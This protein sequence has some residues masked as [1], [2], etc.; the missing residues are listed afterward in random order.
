MYNF[1]ADSSLFFSFPEVMWE[2]IVV[3]Q[4]IKLVLYIL[5]WITHTTGAMMRNNI[6]SILIVLLL[7]LGGTNI[8]LD[9]G[10]RESSVNVSQVTYQMSPWYEEHI[11]TDV[12][13]DG[14]IY[15]RAELQ[16][17]IL[18]FGAYD[19]NTFVDDNLLSIFEWG[20]I[21]TGPS[22]SPDDRNLNI[23][24]NFATNDA[25]QAETLA[26]GMVNAFGSYAN[27]YDVVFTGSFPEDSY[28]G[29]VQHY[30][31]RVTFNGHVDWISFQDIIDISVPRDIGGIAATVDVYQANSLNFNFWSEGDDLAATIGL[32]FNS[33]VNSLQG[34]HSFSL[35]DLVHVS[36]FEPS[37]Y[38][39]LRLDH[40]F[41]DVSNLQYS[42][43]NTSNSNVWIQKNT[44][45]ESHNKDYIW[46]IRTE[47]TGGSYSDITFSFDYIFVP[48]N[49][50]NREE[51]WHSIDPRGYGRADLVVYGTERASP[52][53]TLLPNATVFDDILGLNL[54]V[55]QSVHVIP[56]HDGIWMD[57]F[58]PSGYNQTMANS[59]TEQIANELS[60]I[61]LNFNH[62]NINPNDMWWDESTQESQ[63]VLSVSFDGFIN[64]TE[65]IDMVSST[66]VYSR[67]AAMQ[68]VTLNQMDTFYWNLNRDIYGPYMRAGI[69]AFSLGR[70]EINPT[71][72][73]SQDVQMRAT[74]SLFNLPLMSFGGSIPWNEYSSILSIH[75]ETYFD[76]NWDGLSFQPDRNNGFDWWTNRWSWED[77]GRSFFSYE[78]QVFSS[79]P[80]LQDDNGVPYAPLGSVDVS[81]D[82]KYLPG[83]AD[84]ESPWGNLYYDNGAATGDFGTDHS[85]LGGQVLSGSENIGTW[86]SDQTGPDYWNGTQF[87]QRFPS[88]GIASVMG[89]MYRVDAPVDLPI[90]NIQIPM[91]QDPTYT[92]YWSANLPTT[93]Y[94]DGEWTM[95]SDVFDN[96]GNKGT[97][98]RQFTID[99]YDGSYT[100]ATIT[101]AE[102]ALNHTDVSDIVT[103]HFNV[104]DDV[105]TYATILWNNIGGNIINATN[106]I[107][108]GTDEVTMYEFNF[109]TLTM[110]IENE[111]VKLTVETLDYDGHWSFS[112]LV[113]RIDNIKVG[114][115]PTITLIAPDNNLLIN[116]TE[117]PLL[118]ITA[119]VQDDWGLKS[120]KV[121]FGSGSEFFMFRDNNTGQFTTTIDVSNWKSGSY[122]WKVVAEDVDE[123]THVVTSEMRAFTIQSLNEVDT[124]NPSIELLSPEDHS[125]VNGTVNI[126]FRATDDHGIQ[127]VVLTLPDVSVNSM[128]ASGDEYSTTWDTTIDVDG[129]YTLTVSAKDNS[130]NTATLTLTLTVKNGRT[131]TGPPELGV[132][133]FELPIALFT[134]VFMAIYIRRRKS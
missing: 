14:S 98:E 10:A 128:T 36:S 23:N 113:L 20:D 37:S 103:L 60:T 122:S 73:F 120:V 1:R 76:G 42:V 32:N 121:V 80:Q 15:A 118:T 38:G 116:T 57:V 52:L 11:Y 94:P 16:G 54:H 91:T 108:V 4:L 44:P 24:L 126:R 40:S 83:S 59:T 85:E 110:G 63:S 12:H 62:T 72:V 53:A 41:P 81:F 33:N 19:L 71:P 26:W 89:S 101:W 129:D 29:G 99:N 96:A 46:G 75:S 43:G 82:V 97:T 114:N 69:G 130:G 104:T 55:D 3:F 124:Q 51:V 132:P 133:G 78:V 77:N 47:I 87:L 61:G 49:R 31:T 8:F 45:A 93:S 50:E 106:T 79:N 58:F 25:T 123:N 13:S 105:G 84:I 88:S 9:T 102:S 22:Y 68:A 48:W 92:Q 112:T 100:P 28:D 117:A 2:M 134:S 64:Q 74:L 5:V 7:L 127:Q 66:L 56:G 86:T 90:F 6:T 70:G 65:Y 34:G 17:N 27:F 18:N 107:T 111:E 95:R 109:D 119:D 21:W 125:T 30:R 131:S 39:M 35:K 115:P 67:S